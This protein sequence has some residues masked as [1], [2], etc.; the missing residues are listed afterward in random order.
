[1]AQ[2]LVNKICYCSVNITLYIFRDVSNNSLEC[3]C[4]QL[5]LDW[6]RNHNVKISPMA[7]CGGPMQVRGLSLLQWYDKSSSLCIN[8]IPSLDILKL[9]PQQDQVCF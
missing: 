3:D 7:K 9:Q 1:M 6:V 8:Y 2:D 4:S 5:W